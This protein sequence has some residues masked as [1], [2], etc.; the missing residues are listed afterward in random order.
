MQIVMKGEQNLCFRLDTLFKM[1]KICI[2]LGPFYVKKC[3]NSRFL[4]KITLLANGDVVFQ[5][6]LLLSETFLN[7]AV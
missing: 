6:L 4:G 5:E 3:Q 7:V 1:G 2:Q